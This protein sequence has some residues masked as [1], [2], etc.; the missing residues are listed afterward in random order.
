MPTENEL[1]NPKQAALQEQVKKDAEDK[2]KIR[3]KDEKIVKIGNKKI[4]KISYEKQVN[5]KWVKWNTKNIYLGN[6]KIK[7]DK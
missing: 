7:K 5:G 6:G 3:V 4:K 1:I 2:R